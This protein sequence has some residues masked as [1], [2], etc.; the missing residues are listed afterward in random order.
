MPPQNHVVGPV[1]RLDGVRVK[2][3]AHPL[4]NRLVS[5]LRRSGPATATSLARELG[6][7]SGA[8]SY[9]LRR[10]AELGLVGDTGEGHGRERL[11]AAARDYTQWD[12]A[13]L[14]GDEDA[15]TALNWLERDYLRHMDQ[16]FEKWLDDAASWPMAWRSALGMKDDVCV[17]T[18]D[19]TAEMDAE[20]RAVVERW[21]RVGQGNPDARRIAVYRVTYP[22]D[23]DR[24]PRT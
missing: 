9:H 6:T 19:Q 13:D 7:N 23:L 22:I 24:P 12:P 17:L 1:V 14:G 3:L 5:A 10:L 20:L 4:R 16:R 2:A 21:R 11:W 18:A 8:T 15:E